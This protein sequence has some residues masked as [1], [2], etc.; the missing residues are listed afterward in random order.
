VSILISINVR[1]ESVPKKFLK[2]ILLELRKQGILQ[3]QKGKGAK[4][5]GFLAPRCSMKN[6]RFFNSVIL[7]IGFLGDPVFGEESPANDPTINERIQTL[8]QKV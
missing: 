7:L 6:I 4:V 5:A 1:Q 2:K 8:D 3:C